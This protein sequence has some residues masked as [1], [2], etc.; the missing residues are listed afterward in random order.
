MHVI[1]GL[2]TTIMSRLRTVNYPPPAQS[3]TQVDRSFRFGRSGSGGWVSQTKLYSGHSRG[4]RPLLTPLFPSLQT[5]N[6]ITWA[7]GPDARVLAKPQRGNV[8]VW[9]L[10][11][12]GGGWS[13]PIHIHL[14]GRQG[15]TVDEQG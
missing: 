13:H 10:I 6:G 9:E 14:V 4:L 2:L 1:N 8:E 11:D 7:A 5:V 15:C 12:N 3:A